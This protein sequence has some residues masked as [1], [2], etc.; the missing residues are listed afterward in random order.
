M[1]ATGVLQ[2]WKACVLGEA[3]KANMSKTVNK[4]STIPGVLLL[5]D[6]S[7]PTTTSVGGKKHWTYFKSMRGL[8]AKYEIQIKMIKCDYIGEHCVFEAP[9]KKKENYITFEC[10]IPCMPH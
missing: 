2:P 1:T 6:I 3:K 8:K 4:C 10:T 9:C 7:S 5:I